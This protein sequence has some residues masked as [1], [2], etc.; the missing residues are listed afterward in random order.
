V[1]EPPGSPQSQRTIAAAHPLAER[2]IARLRGRPARILDFAS[3][4]GRNANALRRAGFTVVAIN[5]GSAAAETP[6]IGVGMDFAAALST[7]GLLHGTTSTVAER[8]RW[9]AEHLAERGLLFATFGSSRDTRFG[10]GDRLDASTFAPTLG[11]ER[12]VAHAF[13]D[14][15]R[16]RVLLE[17]FF[18]VES[19]EEHGVDQI[20]GSWA[21]REHPLSGAVHWF[22][23]ARKR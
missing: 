6:L 4:R 17:R 3:G 19:L 20:A 7:H 5:D 22:V 23:V 9:L 10:Q 11:D 15:E 14:G 1:S 2:L 8:V 13:F 16:L 21:H 18:V 12:G